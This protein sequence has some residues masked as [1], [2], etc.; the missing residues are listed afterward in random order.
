M[1]EE[2]LFLG[3]QPGNI[4]F[5]V[6]TGIERT[7]QSLCSVPQLIAVCRIRWRHGRYRFCQIAQDLG[8][9]RIV[10]VHANAFTHVGCTGAVEAERN[11]GFIEM[12]VEARRSLERSNVKLSGY[13]S[14]TSALSGM[15]LVMAR[16]TS[17][18]SND[19]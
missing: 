6:A 5:V 11:S 15:G 2:N 3:R 17:Y 4:V 8:K 1:E 18:E 7:I 16:F 9:Q 19:R 14:A 12:G 13:S 10:K